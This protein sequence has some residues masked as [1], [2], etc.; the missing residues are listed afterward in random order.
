MNILYGDGDKKSESHNYAKDVDPTD[1]W[2]VY[3]LTWTP[4][5]IS[6]NLDGKEVRRVDSSDPAV[7]LSHLKPQRLNMNFWTPTFAKWSDGLN[8]DDLP[9]DLQFDWV[10]TH[11]YDPA[12]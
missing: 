6:F 9:W 1:A 12:S 4:E 2:H 10:E 5:Y 3:E 8:A 11:V 7:K